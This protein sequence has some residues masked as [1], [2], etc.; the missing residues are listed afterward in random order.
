MAIVANSDVKS[1]WELKDNL[2]RLM[3]KPTKW[4]SASKDSDQPGHLPS[5][6]CPYEESLGP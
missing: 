2:S 3:T 4:L 6:R 5:L 1:K